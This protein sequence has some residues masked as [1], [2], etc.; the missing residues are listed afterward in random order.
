M[1]TKL[2]SKPTVNKVVHYGNAQGYNW[3][4][5]PFSEELPFERAGEKREKMKKADL[6]YKKK[7]NG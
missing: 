5:D 1:P 2:T 6:E 3:V 4:H 7:K